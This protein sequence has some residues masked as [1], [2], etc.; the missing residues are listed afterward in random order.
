MELRHLES[1]AVLAEELHFGRAAARLQVSQSAL[2]QQLQRLEAA[3][4]EQL[5]IRTS[6]EVMLTDAGTELLE[7][8]LRVLAAADRAETAIRD[9][10]SGLSGRLRVGSLGAGLNGPLPEVLTRFRE[11]MPA[12][13]VELH[14]SGES[15]DLERS[16]ITGEFDAIIV[17]RLVDHRLITS[18]LIAQESFVVF[19]PTDHLL[20]T[21]DGVRLVDLAEENFVFWRRHL[22]TAFHDS[23]VD[24]CRASGFEPSVT[25]YGDTLEAQLALVAAGYGVSL[26]A[27]TN[28]SV[29]RDGVVMIPVL[30]G[31]VHFRLWMAYL[32]TNRTPAMRALLRSAAPLLD[33]LNDT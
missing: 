21:R 10:R 8:A 16:L 7:P 24:A 20:S 17:R 30:D 28:A 3:L 11:A 32:E 1:F 14:H 25:A 31:D 27:A 4:G 19:L 9:L 18:R 12:S 33:A 22:G 6:R 26:Q 23:I 29:A 15:A 13:I 5:V 2:S